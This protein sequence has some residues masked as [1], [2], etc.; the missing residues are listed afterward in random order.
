MTHFAALWALLTCSLPALAGYEDVIRNI[1]KDP[2]SARFHEVQKFLNG[3]VCGYLNAKNSFGGYIGKKSFAFVSGR[4]LLD[5]DTY[6]VACEIAS[7]PVQFAARRAEENRRAQVKKRAEAEAAREAER[8]RALKEENE[9]TR[10]EQVAY[11]AC[12]TYRHLLLAELMH[13]EQLHTEIEPQHLKASIALPDMTILAL[14]SCPRRFLQ[15]I[16]PVVNEERKRLFQIYCVDR[17]PQRVR[18]TLSDGGHDRHIAEA[19]GADYLRSLM[20]SNFYKASELV[21]ADRLANPA[22]WECRVIRDYTTVGDKA[23]KLY[24]GN[25]FQ[26]K[27]AGLN[28]QLDKPD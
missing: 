6:D 4:A 19:C 9:R 16:A 21:K 15:E 8:R 14:A 24:W 2:E 27:C 25:E 5:L 17:R 20:P 18:E 1:L 10:L 26:S 11:V 23:S 7:D 13:V 22:L 12:S 3:N 28:S